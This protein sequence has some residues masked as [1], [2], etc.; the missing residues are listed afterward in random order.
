[1]TERLREYL[2]GGDALSAVIPLSTGH[3]NETYLLE[4]L[5]RIL[6]MPPSEEGLLP[7]YDMARQHAVLRAIGVSSGGPP[8]PRVFELCEDATVLGDPFF[9][10]ERLPGEAFEYR[11]PEWVATGTAELRDRM[12][13]QW[14]G[15]VAALH[16][17]PSDAMPA[18]TLTVGDEAA[19]WREVAIRADAPSLLLDLLDDLRRRPPAASGPPAPVHGDSKH[20]NCLWDHGRL[21]ALLDWEMAHVGEPLTDLGYL[22]SFYAQGEGVALANAGFELE[23]WWPRSRAVEEW[24]ALTGRVARDLARYEVLGMC[25]IA[26]IIALGYRLY[27]SGRATDARFAAWGAVIPPYL[28]LA[29]RR[30]DRSS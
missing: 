4:G 7:P 3:S 20:G 27:T 12:C 1:M 29:A 16:R 22:T 23:G 13:A 14:I 30:A 11:V 10:M 15:A 24:E 17:M 19:H 6:R 9:L 2:D 26:S 18:P 5:D 21:V 8:V 25:K 28:E